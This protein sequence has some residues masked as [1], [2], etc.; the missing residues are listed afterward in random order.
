MSV[1]IEAVERAAFQLIYFTISNFDVN[2]Y[3]LAYFKHF[4]G[5]LGTGSLCQK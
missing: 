3:K 4:F 2:S 1:R 5:A